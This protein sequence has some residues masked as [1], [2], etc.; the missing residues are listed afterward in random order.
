MMTFDMVLTLDAVAEAEARRRCMW[1][2]VNRPVFRGC[3]GREN[4]HHHT[5][6]E[7]ANGIR[8]IPS[9]D[10]PNAIVWPTG[11]TR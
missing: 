2:A 7:S 9:D 10:C 6:T 5:L 11:A 1:C 8:A 4:P 3:C